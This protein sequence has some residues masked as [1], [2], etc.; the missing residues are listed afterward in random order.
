M[1]NLREPLMFSLKCL[2]AIVPVVLLQAIGAISVVAPHSNCYAFDNASRLVDFT[3]WIGRTFV[4]D[5]EDADIVVRF[6]KDVESRSQTGYVGFGQFERFN[7]INIGSAN[8]DFI[9]GFYKGDLRNCEN[10]YEKLGRTSQVNILCGSCSN[11]KCKGGI[12]C[13]CNVTYESTCRIVVELAISCDKSGPRVFEGFTVGFHPRSWEIVYNGLTQPGFEKS[14]QEFSF[15]TEQTRVVLYMTAVASVSSLVRK[16]IIK[17]LPKNGLDVRLSG[18]GATGSPPT[19]LSPTML[20][21]DWTCKEARDTPYE[22]D[23]TI[24]IEGY[25]PIHFVLTKM[26]EHRQNQQEDSRRGWA[27]FGMLSCI[28]F[29]SFTLVCVGGFVYKTRVEHLRGINALPGMT[30]LSAC[31]E[32]V[33]DTRHGYTRAE[34]LNSGYSSE[35]SWERSSASAQEKFRAS[36]RNYGSI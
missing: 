19:T 4:Y 9:Q 15:N 14:S 26:C 25:E 20:V 22:I 5:G 17:V 1:R 3:S 12:E 10:T 13:I 23:V 31:L 24:P 34:D 35:A 2:C 8:A 30:I 18:T 11:G 32:T 7:Y 27:F 28:F 6:C 16:P 29:V 33:S 36:E 21:M